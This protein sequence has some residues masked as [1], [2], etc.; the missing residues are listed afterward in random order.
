MPRKTTKKLLTWGEPGETPVSSCT[1]W[2][3]TDGRYRIIQADNCR[4]IKIPC[5]YTVWFKEYVPGIA[6]AVF[7]KIDEQRSKKKAFNAAERHREAGK[8]C[9]T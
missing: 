8:Q 5:V 3:T 1:F 4:G 7:R 2:E 6:E 9:D